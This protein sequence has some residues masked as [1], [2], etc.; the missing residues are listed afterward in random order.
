M[1]SPSSSFSAESLRSSL[2]RSGAERDVSGDSQ[3]PPLQAGQAYEFEFAHEGEV[4][5][6][7]GNGVYFMAAR[8]NWYPQRGLQFAPHEATFRYPGRFDVGFRGR[9]V[10]LEDRGRR[11]RRSLEDGGAGPHAGLQLGQVCAQPANA[12]R[13]SA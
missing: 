11:A 5:R 7:A 12:R 2:F 4:I 10:E 1:A 9:S 8:T 3:G 13:L 6:D